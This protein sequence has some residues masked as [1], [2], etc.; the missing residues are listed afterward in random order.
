MD[1]AQRK[2]RFYAWFDTPPTKRRPRFQS[3]LAKELGVTSAT[4][5]TWR[6]KR[7]AEKKVTIPL[8]KELEKI[9]SFSTEELLAIAIK[10]DNAKMSHLAKI[11]MWFIGMKEGNYKSLESYLKST[12]EFIE[13]RED[14]VKYEL[15]TEDREQIARRSAE[16][17]RDFSERGSGK[18]SVPA[19]PALLS[20]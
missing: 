20:Q 15:T 6:K 16:I 4:L 18:D 14:T 19:K 5:N 8:E 10:G 9:S 1:K 7:E 11:Q 3:Q 12:G 17:L 13:K 2:K